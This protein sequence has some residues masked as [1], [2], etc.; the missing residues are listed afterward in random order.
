MKLHGDSDRLAIR[1]ELNNTGAYDGEEV[2]QLYI[3]DPVA[4]V[5]RVVRKL[6]NFQKVFLRTQER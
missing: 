1:V 2:V 3:A 6:K 5:T 4:S